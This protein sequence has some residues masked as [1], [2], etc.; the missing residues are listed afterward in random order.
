ME[1]E[2]NSILIEQWKIKRLIKRLDEAKG[3][4]NDD[5]PPI[6]PP[7]F[8]NGTSMISLIIPAKKAITD[9]TKMLNDEQG[10]AVNIKSNVNRK[11]VLTA[12]TS[13][14]ESTR[15]FWFHIEISW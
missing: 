11:S 3:Y 9:I 15:L 10:T 14:R 12:I 7:I 5:W 4:R 8:R 6:S 1:A 13:A 2:D